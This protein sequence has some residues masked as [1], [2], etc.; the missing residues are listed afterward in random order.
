MKSLEQ[1]VSVRENVKMKCPKCGFGQPDDI[2]CALCGINVEKYARKKKTRYY[3]VGA[4]AVMAA[5][6][7]LVV[8][9]HLS[10]TSSTRTDLSDRTPEEISPSTRRKEA[11]E[12]N[13]VRETESRR[14]SYEDRSFEE[15]PSN[16]EQTA[17][18]PGAVEKPEYPTPPE[19]VENQLETAKQWFEKGRALDD[20][21]ENEIECYKTALDIDP[22]FAPAAFRLGSIYFRKARYELADE[23]FST[24]LRHASEQERRNYD[25][26]VY[27]S[28]ADVERLYDGLA[29]ETAEQNAQEEE[30]TNGGTGEEEPGEANG[31]SGEEVL[32]I[33]EYR[34]VNGHITVPIVL[35]GFYSTRLLV[36]TAAGITIVSNEIA[37]RLQLADPSHPPITLRTLAMD[38]SAQRGQLESIQVGNL[39]KHDFPIAIADPPFEDEHGFSGILGMDFMKD[40]SITIDNETKRII[41][42][43]KGTRS[44]R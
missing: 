5:I 35:N 32:T 21:S 33:V 11:V 2:Y 22:E 28:L 14:P 9:N 4:M 19:E 20:D 42:S 3:K 13:I 18:K 37:R 39:K 40:Y 6:V 17:F 38:V 44:R 41:L 25:I 23:Y 31:E 27:Y 7:A 1:H 26:Y 16:R 12:A 8:V 34:T 30:S 43:N 24:F 10:P 36:D 29:Q 15:P